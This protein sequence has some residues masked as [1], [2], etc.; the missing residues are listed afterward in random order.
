MEPRTEELAAFYETYLS[1]CNAHRFDE[2]GVFVASDVNG[3]TQ[4][5]D[6]YIGG[7]EEVVEAFPDYHWD[8]QRLLVDDLWL[9]ARLYGTGTHRGTFRGVAATGRVIRTQELVIY[10]L[11][12]GKI[13]ECWGDLHTTVRDELTFGPD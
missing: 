6:A 1:L 13:A 8:L 9:A 5:L 10:R 2:L 3:S 12:G 4:G 11:A 7:L